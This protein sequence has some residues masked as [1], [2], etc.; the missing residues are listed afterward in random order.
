MIL[1]SN[2]NSLRGGQWPGTAFMSV[3]PSHGGKGGSI[4]AEKGWE[5]GR[6]AHGGFVLYYRGFGFYSGM[7]SSWRLLYKGTRCSVLGFN[8]TAQETALQIDHG[9]KLAEASAQ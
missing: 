9:G 1:V 3:R 7:G 5:L 8:R 4:R 6:K 2:S